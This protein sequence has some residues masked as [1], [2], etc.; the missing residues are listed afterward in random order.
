MLHVLLALSLALAPSPSDDPLTRLDTALEQVS[1][2]PETGL[3][4]LVDALTTLESNPN[5]VLDH[6]DLLERR[7]FARLALARAYLSLDKPELAAAAMDT[8]LRRSAGLDLPANQLGPGTQALHD[9]RRTLLLEQGQAQIEVLCET[10]CRL[11]VD[12]HEVTNP[13]PPLFLGDHRI[14]ILALDG[15][16]PPEQHTIELEQLEEPLV[17]TYPTPHGPSV[18]DELPPAN[19]AANP[20]RSPSPVL[21]IVGGGLLSSSLVLGIYGSVF[22]HRGVVELDDPGYRDIRILDYRPPAIALLATA[23][24]FTIAGTHPPH[25]RPSSATA[26]PAPAPPRPPSS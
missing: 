22:L 24:A 3:P 9:D 8:A 6:P 25:R 21:P 26:A 4:Q 1:R 15:A 17:L 16:A 11:F 12:E 2:D 7:T 23:T 10:P 20:Q 5:L 19:T 18:E 14:H 13:S